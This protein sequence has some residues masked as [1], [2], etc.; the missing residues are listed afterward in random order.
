MGKKAIA[1]MLNETNA[2]KRFGYT[3]WRINTVGYIL[4]NERYIGDALF[5]KNYTTDTL[6]FVS[7]PN[8]GEKAQY[9]VENMNPPIIILTAT[10]KS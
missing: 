2:P 4:T 3:T 1:D 9:Y 8:R 10:V 5:Q 6:P 7:K